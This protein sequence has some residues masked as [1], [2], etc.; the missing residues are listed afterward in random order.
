MSKITKKTSVAVAL[1]LVTSGFVV[2]C[3]GGVTCV[4]G[5]SKNAET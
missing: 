2:A 5:A 1:L 3:K 4:D